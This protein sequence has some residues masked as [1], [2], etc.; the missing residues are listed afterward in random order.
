VRSDQRVEW[1]DRLPLRRN[2]S[3]TSPEVRAAASSKGTTSNSMRK[4]SSFAEP[5]SE[6]SAP[7]QE[8]CVARHVPRC[9]RRALDSAPAAQPPAQHPTA[10]Q[11][12][13]QG[14]EPDGQHILVRA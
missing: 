1:P 2:S 11:D 13:R 4:R 10:E 8:Q 14:E 6:W 12:H 9:S 3:L 5:S 7:R